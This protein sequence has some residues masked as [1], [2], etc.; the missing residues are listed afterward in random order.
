[1]IEFTITL[2]NK[3]ARKCYKTIQSADFT[4]DVGYLSNGLTVDKHV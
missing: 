3:V 1:M 4:I 2:H